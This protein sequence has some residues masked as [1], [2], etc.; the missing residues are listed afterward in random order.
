MSSYTGNDD[1]GG[2]TG[3]YSAFGTVPVVGA[4]G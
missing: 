1:T 2:L 3:D 4:G